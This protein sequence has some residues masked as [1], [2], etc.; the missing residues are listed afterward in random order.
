MTL[1]L[2]VIFIAVILVVI[3][4]ILICKWTRVRGIRALTA[5]D[6][7]DG[8]SCHIHIR[9]ISPLYLSCQTD[10]GR[11]L[12][13]DERISQ[14]IASMREG[15]SEEELDIK[16]AAVVDGKDYNLSTV[17]KCAFNEGEFAVIRP[18]S[19]VGQRFIGQ[20]S[21]V[22][23]NKELMS[24]YLIKTQ[25][26]VVRQI[27]LNREVCAK[28]LE[29]KVTAKFG[30]S[31]VCVYKHGVVMKPSQIIQSMGLMLHMLRE[32]SIVIGGNES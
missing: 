14:S 23:D 25:S 8:F 9:C 4:V 5:V 18:M 10:Y 2:I 22:S 31:E 7:I 13:Q 16:D 21:D 30:Y 32:A 17:L 6:S 19:L 28:L 20:T 27:L 12:V 11:I 1:Y 15:S 26:A 24:E 3:S 29:N